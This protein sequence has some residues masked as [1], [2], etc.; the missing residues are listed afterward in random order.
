MEDNELLDAE[1][2]KGEIPLNEAIK[3]IIAGKSILTFEFSTPASNKLEHFTFKISAAKY[4]DKKINRN[5]FFVS[6]LCGQNNDTDYKYFGLIRIIN[7]SPIYEFS[8]K[9]KIKRDSRT[10]RT[11][12][13]VWNTLISG[14]TFKTL[15]IYYSS[16]CCRCGRTLTV[17]ESIKNGLGAMCQAL[18]AMGK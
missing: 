12:E 6:A 3:Y 1:L 9:A 14:G 17:A 8:I 16:K 2:M 15:K 10:V 13:H 18:F 4:Q 11:F 5:L 7:G